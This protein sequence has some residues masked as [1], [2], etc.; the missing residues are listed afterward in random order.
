MRFLDQ[1]KRRSRLQSKQNKWI[2]LK[3]VEVCKNAQLFI[4]IFVYN[5]VKPALDRCINI[6]LLFSR[7]VFLH[8]RNAYMFETESLTQELFTYLLPEQ[9]ICHGCSPKHYHKVSFQNNNLI[10]HVRV[11]VIVSH[12]LHLTSSAGFLKKKL[13]LFFNQ[14]KAYNL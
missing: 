1:T 7:E 14:S 12:L 9:I 6:L 3:S 5:T 10:E 2:L 4:A 8:L 11:V 13:L